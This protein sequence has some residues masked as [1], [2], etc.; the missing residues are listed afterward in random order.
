MAGRGAIAFKL[1]PASG[2]PGPA[3]DAAPATAEAAA[4]G[5]DRAPSQA[6]KPLGCRAGCI[7]GAAVA[8]ARMR[9]PVARAESVARRDAI[10]ATSESRTPPGAALVAGLFITGA[11]GVVA[12]VL[13][14]TPSR[15]APP[16]ELLSSI[17]R[18]GAAVWPAAAALLAAARPTPALALC[19]AL[20]PAVSFP[21]ELVWQSVL[22]DA[23]LSPLFPA[24][25]ADAATASSLP[26]QATRHLAIASSCFGALLSLWW[27]RRF[28]RSFLEA[29]RRRRGR[30]ALARDGCPQHTGRAAL[31][32][33]RGCCAVGL[34][35]LA[36][37]HLYGPCAAERDY[38]D[39][40]GEPEAQAS[41]GCCAGVCGCG[42]G[43][44]K[45]SG[46]AKSSGSGRAEQHR[47]GDALGLDLAGVV[48][49]RTGGD[50]AGGQAGFPATPV[51]A[52]SVASSRALLR[53]T[54]RGGALELAAQSPPAGHSAGAGAE[55]DE[56]AGAGAEAEADEGGPDALELPA[57]RP[58]AAEASARRPATP[59]AEGAPPGSGAAAPSGS[60]SRRLSGLPTAASTLASLI[61]THH[62]WQLSMLLYGLEAAL[63]GAPQH[64]IV[65][66]LLGLAA[67]QTLSPALFF[68]YALSLLVA[69]RVDQ[70]WILANFP[71]QGSAQLAELEAAGAPG[72]VP[73]G[74]GIGPSDEW[75]QA[76]L[77]VAMVCACLRGVATP[78]AMVSAFM[79]GQ[80]ACHRG[81]RV[82]WRRAAAA[83]AGSGGSAAATAVAA[84]V[85]PC[86]FERPLQTPAHCGMWWSLGRTAALG[87]AAA[88]LSPVAPATGR[89]REAWA[90]DEVRDP[91]L[92]LR[93]ATSTAAGDE[94]R[95]GAAD[96]PVEAASLNGSAGGKPALLG[97]PAT[98]R[99]G[100]G[101]AAGPASSAPGPRSR[102]A[103]VRDAGWSGDVA[104]G[105]VAGAGSSA[106]LFWLPFLAAA[107]G[108]LFVASLQGASGYAHHD[109]QEPCR[110]EAWRAE[111][112][113]ASGH[114]SVQG[115]EAAGVQLGA[116]DAWEPPPL[117]Q[118]A[119]HPPAAAAVGLAAAAVASLAGTL[120]QLMAGAA[121]AAAAAASL[122]AWGGVVAASEG[123]ASF[124]GQ[125]MEGSAVTARGLALFLAL[126]ACVLLLARAL[127]AGLA[128]A[129]LLADS[130]RARLRDR[131]SAKDAAPVEEWGAARSRSRRALGLRRPAAASGAA[132]PPPHERAGVPRGAQARSTRFGFAA[133]QVVADDI[134]G[135]TDDGPG[136][137][138]VRAVS[139]R[140]VGS[141]SAAA[142]M[143]ENPLAGLQ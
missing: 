73:G 71:G 140:A 69:N 1:K 21:A 88:L 142:A 94:A 67:L 47:S 86:S 106:A 63:P 135:E 13:A 16:A 97:M 112:G 119:A 79:L 105:C 122:V 5:A 104:A 53:G 114:D 72:L 77:T 78:L 68:A 124:A 14:E 143:R 30:A 141:A 116:A 101:Q 127:M 98:K 59:A 56:D 82:G 52:A 120:P 7:A 54:S 76:L 9:R 128:V 96:G 60:V 102:S 92:V 10:S 35:L 28:A 37:R 74:P 57:A 132:A 44:S 111:Q 24:D 36:P 42:F 8:A 31:A 84:C 43:A 109:V 29:V 18:T 115:L 64:G 91:D 61:A 50:S 27:A 40:G 39:V 48:S 118:P 121:A 125:L 3:S 70:V 4:A 45:H 46:R 22:S 65:S 19:A 17:A 15:H 87:R 2:P 130:L 58:V 99:A 108:A 136:E 80:M 110:L 32:A 51:S 55:A 117:W 26:A 62:V 23:R 41:Q 83:A 137:K 138:R 33:V 95:A 85:G 34:T 38:E 126:S 89:E 25:A 90:A 107:V 100:A 123:G 11:A 134:G 12:A 103:L 133:V 139:R 6:A 75:Q 81:R 49:P 113:N 129:A 66:G 93:R 20:A 131:A